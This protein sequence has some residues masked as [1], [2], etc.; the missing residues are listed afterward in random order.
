MVSHGIM[1]TKVY[2]INLSA[3]KVQHFFDSTKYIDYFAKKIMEEVSHFH[4]FLVGH[5]PILVE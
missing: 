1:I 5:R 4:Y 2:D 3:A